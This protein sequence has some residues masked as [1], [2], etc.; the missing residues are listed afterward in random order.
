MTSSEGRAGRPGLET[1]ARDAH[2]EVIPLRSLADQLSELPVTTNVTIT[3]SPK[4]GLARTLDLAERLVGAGYR[5][6]P[7]LA[8]R[9]V[10]DEAELRSFLDA[11]GELG[12]DELFVVG[13]DGADP[14]GEFQTSFEILSAMGGLEHRIRRI[15]V[16][17]Y[18]EGHPS[19][20]RGELLA[21]LLA[22][23]ALAHYMVSQLCFDA[24][25]LENWLRQARADGVVLPLRIG[26][27]A[28]LNSRKLVELSLRVGVGSSLR[29]LTKQHG[30][31]RRALHGSAY[32]PEQLLIGLG[33][34]L[35][36][37]ELKIEGL[38]LFSFNQLPATVDWQRRV[39]SGNAS[40]VARRLRS[41]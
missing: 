11:L 36:A 2:I 34:A 4:F 10:R 9:Q 25:A 15:G 37:P 3:C 24:T 7:H 40:A 38:H 32:R 19:V 31:V 18:P 33:G 17:C 41:R 27:A 21:A 29:F 26:L 14:V 23:Q 1:L 13:G 35:L 16:A 39:S 22:K 12:V 30:M 28:P 20:P 8:A 5:V 6:V